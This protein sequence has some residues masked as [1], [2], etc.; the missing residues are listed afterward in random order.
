MALRVSLNMSSREIKL[1]I[2]EGA[3]LV[4]GKH[5]KIEL[6]GIHVK[7][8]KRRRK[9]DEYSMEAFW[10]LFRIVQIIIPLEQVCQ[11]LLE[12]G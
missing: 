4:F 2:N 5:Y 9:Y 7:I 11:H 8:L 10:I 1:G 3:K 12:L 6:D